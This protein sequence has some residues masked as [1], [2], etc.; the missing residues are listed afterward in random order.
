MNRR[1][2]PNGP[3]GG[4]IGANTPNARS[5][6]VAAFRALLRIGRPVVGT[7]KDRKVRRGPGTAGRPIRSRGGSHV[8]VETDDAVE[9]STSSG[10]EG[11]GGQGR[12]PLDD[13][14][15][16][17]GVLR[18]SQFF[19]AAATRPA[20]SPGFVSLP[21]PTPSLPPVWK[22]SRVPGSWKRA[23]PAPTPFVPSTASVQ[24]G[25]VPL[26]FRPQV[27]RAPS[28]L[29]YVSL[30]PSPAIPTG[31]SGYLSFEP[32]QR[33]AGGIGPTLPRDLA[34]RRLARTASKQPFIP[35]LTSAAA[36]DRAAKYSLFN[37]LVGSAAG[38]EF[39]LPVNRAARYRPFT[40]ASAGRIESPLPRSFGLMNRAAASMRPY[41]AS[42]PFVA[43]RPGEIARRS[44]TPPSRPIGGIDFA[45][46]LRLEGCDGR[47]SPMS[48][49]TL[50]AG[51]RGGTGFIAAPAA[52]AHAVHAR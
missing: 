47:R 30:P 40:A 36:P 44:Y 17:E 18:D 33:P 23:D 20:D 16:G 13:G 34:I 3:S 25:S 2:D 39:K 24:F 38:M 50:L 5:N 37:P 42:G 7:D 4:H 32:P 6:P 35:H 21:L 22:I 48:I 41:D 43:A 19:S 15:P 45:G 12:A 14:G 1:I 52:V 27:R 29:P 11:D 10:G 49:D 51:L 8:D 31:R 26:V 28:V 9:A 46:A